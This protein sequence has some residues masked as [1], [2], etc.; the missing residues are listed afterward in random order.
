MKALF[1]TN[2]YPPHIYGG[3]GIH[4]EY[5]TRELAKRIGVEVRCFGEQDFSKGSL[6]AKGYA[7]P[8]AAFKKCDPRLK[9]PLAAFANGIA[10]NADPTKAHLVHCHTWYSHF[11]GLLAKM[12][13]GLP[14][15]ITTHSL[16]PLRP[17]KREQLGRGYDLS[18]W[19]ED[20][21]L[22]AADAVIAVSRG[23]KT[24]ILRLFDVDEKKIR[25]IHNGIDVE[26]YRARKNPATLRKYG[27]DPAAP[28]VLFFGRITRQKGIIHLVNAVKY[29]SPKTQ[30]VLCAGQPDTPEIQR[31]MEQSVR[32]V[33][34]KRTNLR[35]IREW[36]DTRAKIEIYSHAAAFCCPSIYEPFGIINL[37]A[38]A[39]GVPVVG[40][41]VGGIKEI[42][43]HGK[44][45]YL[46]PLAQQKQSPFE[47]LSP[48][49]F[50]RD[51]AA[52]LNRL[53]ADDAL[54]DR[55]GRASRRRVEQF[56]SWKS[57]ARQTLELYKT[58]IRRGKNG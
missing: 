44:T 27:I 55:L 4:V 30:V 11:G 10:F 2:E 28:Y 36:L 7:P 25:V 26:E 16:E 29:L 42:V 32:K 48:D 54:R 12:A 41:A 53:L 14:L 51:L 47:A 33:Q 56:F 31:E 18:T 3:A 22:R 57:I 52:P 37:E 20:T 21:A 1:L 13:Y 46:V 17:W 38:M 50:A 5:L 39:C 15:V 43:E 19:V 23:M 40:S 49:R 9:S 24:D 45:G 58:L 6:R 34:K 35:W 8:T